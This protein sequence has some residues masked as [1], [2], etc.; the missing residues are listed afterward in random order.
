MFR[1][2]LYYGVKP[3]LP[4]LM[5]RRVRRWFALRKRERVRDVWPILPGSERPPSGWE[6]WPE[7]KRFAVVLTHDVEGQSGLDKCR[8]LMQ[9]EARLGFRSS[10]N[11]V[12]EGDYAVSKELRG[13]LTA[14][15]F[16]VGVHDLHHNG[17]L[18]R[19]RKEFSKSA[20]RINR[21]LREW[22]AVGFRS[23][24]MLHNL[25]WAHDLDVLYEASTFDTDPFEPQ[26]DGVGT[27]FP[28]WVPRPVTSGQP[29]GGGYIELP[30]TLPQDSTI[31]LILSE[32]HPD[33]WLQKLDWVA[34][35]GGMVLVNTH[36]D[37]MNMAGI[38]NGRWEYP[39]GFY[40][41]LLQ[42]ISS[43]YAGEYWSALPKEMAQYWRRAVVGRSATLP[44]GDTR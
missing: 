38:K 42:Y 43:H 33:I 9:I 28:F 29:A 15:G 5:R 26:P 41:R 37:Y 1:N 7:S 10:F 34:K 6:G 13:E 4:L 11:F 18:Y 39:V 36:P 20:E 23:G 32:N 30:Y 35:H 3:L 14:G 16:E 40:E 8:R 22:G 17:K 31:F 21:Y 44:T 24:F 25:V 19:S 2:R 12:P 27:I